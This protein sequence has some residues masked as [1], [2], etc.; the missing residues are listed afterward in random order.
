VTS[1][2]HHDNATPAPR[3]RLTSHQS[4]VM[5]QPFFGNGSLFNLMNTIVG[6]EA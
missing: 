4:T 6:E 2:Q 5:H 3:Q 1:Q